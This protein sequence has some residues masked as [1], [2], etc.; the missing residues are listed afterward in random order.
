[1]NALLALSIAHLSL[2][3]SLKLPHFLNSCTDNA[4]CDNNAESETKNT[5]VCDGGYE[6][7]ETSGEWTV[8][9]NSQNIKDGLITIHFVDYD[10][11]LVFFYRLKNLGLIDNYY[12]SIY[13]FFRVK[14]IIKARTNTLQRKI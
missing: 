8:S 13:E 1:M 4:H 5:C 6:Y 3:L 12:E 14:D 10:K 2:L 11:V 7:N 9:I